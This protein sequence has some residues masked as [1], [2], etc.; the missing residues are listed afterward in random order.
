MDAMDNIYISFE[1]LD[2]K[3]LEVFCDICT[4]NCKNL[5]L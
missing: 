3:I 1:M 5:L 4:Y 2:W